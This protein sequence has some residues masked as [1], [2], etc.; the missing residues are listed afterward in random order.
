[1][2]EHARDYLNENGPEY[3]QEDLLKIAQKHHDLYQKQVKPCILD[4]YLLNIIIWSEHKYGVCHP[5]IKSQWRYTKFEQ[6]FL[7][8]P[9]IV[10]VQDGLR[11]L[12]N[13]RASIF[14]LFQK[15][16]EMQNRQFEIIDVNKP[17][18]IEKAIS[19]TIPFIN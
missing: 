11:E 14:E 18:D 9:T 5:W 15:N 19:K 17:S 12:E 6:I 16:L 7:L 2:P 10:W 4:T 8:R 3:K 1:M 13:E